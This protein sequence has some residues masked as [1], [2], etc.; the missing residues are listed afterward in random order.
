MVEI[1]EKGFRMYSGRGASRADMVMIQL[2]K[3]KMILRMFG[4]SN[5]QL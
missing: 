4:L 1:E 5:W 3:L 2:A